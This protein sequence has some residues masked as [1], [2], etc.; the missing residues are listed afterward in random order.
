MSPEQFGKLT[1]EEQ[2]RETEKNLKSLSKTQKTLERK[3]MFTFHK[4]GM[5]KGGLVLEW[6]PKK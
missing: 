2:K 1:P 6:N 3:G 5:K 4:E